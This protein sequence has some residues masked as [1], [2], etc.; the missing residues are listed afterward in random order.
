ML[1]FFRNRW[2]IDTPEEYKQFRFGLFQDEWDVINVTQSAGPQLADLAQDYPTY[3]RYRAAVICCPDGNQLILQPSSR[4]VMAEFKSGSPLFANLPKHYTE[5]IISLEG[6]STVTAADINAIFNWTRVDKMHIT[7]NGD[8][9]LPLS[10]RIHE[11]KS[12]FVTELELTVQRSSYKEL[13]VK[14]LLEAWPIKSAT[15]RGADD[16]T[17]EEFDEFV[18]RQTGIRHYKSVYGKELRYQG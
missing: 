5:Y 9:A 15:F 3:A 4:Q 11:M 14:P 16:M 2:T 12:H 7:G 17:Q 18:N 8:I 10:Q 6:N 13:L 1:L